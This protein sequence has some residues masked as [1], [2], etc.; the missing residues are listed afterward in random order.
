MSYYGEPCSHTVDEYF[1]NGCCQDWHNNSLPQLT[2]DHNDVHWFRDHQ[3]TCQCCQPFYTLPEELSTLHHPPMSP[4]IRDPSNCSHTDKTMC[5]NTST[6]PPD[7]CNSHKTAT[8]LL[9]GINIERDP[10]TCVPFKPW[11][12]VREA[13]ELLLSPDI[14]SL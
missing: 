4:M 1:H 3:P 13:Q 12:A 6:N 10:I 2:N 7:K 5:S 8:G 9:E 11:V 14:I